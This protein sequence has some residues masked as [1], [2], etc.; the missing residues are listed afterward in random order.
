MDDQDNEAMPTFIGDKMDS[1][2]KPVQSEDNENN[3]DGGES[4][5]NFEVTDEQKELFGDDSTFLLSN[6][7]GKDDVSVTESLVTE[8]SQDSF[9][10]IEKCGHCK[11]DI[12]GDNLH[13]Y[14]KACSCCMNTV[15]IHKACVPDFLTETLFG[16]DEDQTFDPEKMTPQAFNKLDVEWYCK[17]CNQDCFYCNTSHEGMFIV[18]T[19]LCITILSNTNVYCSHHIFRLN[20]HTEM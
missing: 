3:S 7:G 18:N 5:D 12:I 2:N 1:I 19:C 13:P 8:A 10:R 4:L 17:L 14:M 15:K 16:A 9:E 11:E 20:N 6:D